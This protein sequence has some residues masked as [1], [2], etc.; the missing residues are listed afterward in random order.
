MVAFMPHR[1]LI[2]LALAV[3][4]SAFAPPCLAGTA[5]HLFAPGPAAALLSVSAHAFVPCEAI[6]GD[7]MR[8]GTHEVRVRGVRSAPP[9]TP[10]GDAALENLRDKLQSGPPIRLHRPGLAGSP[11]RLVADV[12]VGRALLRQR[13]VGPK[14]TC[15][16]ARDDFR[17]ESNRQPFRGAYEW[18]ADPPRARGRRCHNFFPALT[19]PGVDFGRFGRVVALPVP[20]SAGATGGVYLS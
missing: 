6:A 3:A 11:T 4:A 19:P 14:P 16:R 15:D 7:A 20:M 2:L 5:A 12:R 8:C 10:A 1:V 9:G 13:D 17:A 18:L